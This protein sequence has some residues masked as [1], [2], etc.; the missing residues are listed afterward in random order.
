MSWDEIVLNNLTT[1]IA[2]YVKEIEVVE[3]EILD[4]N[5]KNPEWYTPARKDTKTWYTLDSKGARKLDW[6]YLKDYH[7]PSIAIAGALL[8][9]VILT[10]LGIQVLPDTLLFNTDLF[11]DVLLLAY[12]AAAFRQIPVNVVVAVLRFS[13]PV[14]LPK[15]GLAFVLRG[16]FSLTKATVNYRDVRF[17]GPPDKIFRI[18]LEQQK[19]RAEGDTPDP[20]YCRPILATTGAPILEPEEA[21]TRE[22][23]PADYALDRQF[24]V[25]IEFFFRF[26]PNRD[27]GGILRI[28]RNLSSI[29]EDIDERIKDLM[30]EQS[31]AEAKEI[32]STLTPAMA[33]RHLSLVN[34]LFTLRVR[35][36]FLRLG[37]QIDDGGGF[38]AI[39]LSHELNAAITG[40]ST[41][42]LN[43][44]AAITK[45]QGD[46]QKAILEGEGE[47]GRLEA[48]RKGAGVTGAAILASEAVRTFGDKTVILGADGI[49]QMAGTVNVLAD[50]IRKNSGS[51]P[52]TN[53]S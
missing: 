25:D 30:R 8:G 11:V 26:R 52:T 7:L 24:T 20:G 32:L 1:E 47:G 22:K 9:F 19:A 37:I 27:L 33:L 23:S 48:I 16:I 15:P 36:R 28:I 12:L 43:A 3:R 13:R 34:K 50:A 40:V 53:A 31:E 46:R 4:E 41:A 44:K 42:E 21:K 35:R 2:R 51:E 6:G 14:Y 29:P 10:M 17:P 39:N 5:N 38:V 49:M 45:A 18:T